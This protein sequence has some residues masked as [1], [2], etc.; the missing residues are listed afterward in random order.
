MRNLRVFLGALLLAL[1]AVGCDSAEED[2]TDAEI[3]VGSWTVVAVS[4]SEGDK[5]DVFSEGVSSFS[6]TIND[7]GTYSLVVSFVD[8]DRSP[9]A[10]AG[11]YTVDEGGENLMLS[12]GAQQLNFM[13]DIRSEN[14]I[15]LS[16]PAAVVAAVF[17][18]Q[19]DTYSDTVTFTVDRV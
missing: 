10:L 11:D 7:D 6:A 5:T 9:V 14:R 13:Y 17:G 2:L 15:D 4:D 19:P 3:F 8:P 12:A 1:V 18:T 16:L